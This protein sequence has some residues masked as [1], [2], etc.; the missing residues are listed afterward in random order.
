MKAIAVARRQPA[1]RI[2]LYGLLFLI[3][4]QLLS[5]FVAG[6]YAFG[7]LGTAIPPEI[8]SVLLLFS[9]LLLPLLGKRIAAGHLLSLGLF[10]L[11]S[12]LLEPYL[13]TRGQM[14]VSGVGTSA[15]LL[16]FPTMLRTSARQRHDSEGSFLGAGLALAV[17]MSILIKSVN[18]GAYRPAQ[19]WLQLIDWSLILLTALLL[20]TVI[21][22]GREKVPDRSG[23]A[24]G[25]RSPK[26]GTV[27]GMSIGLSA[28][29]IF[30]YFAY[31]SPNVIARWTGSG[32]HWIQAVMLLALAASAFLFAGYRPFRF[33]LTPRGLWLGNLLFVLSLV[34]TIL[35]HQID[36]PTGPG[37]YPFSEPAGNAL[38]QIPLYLSLILFPIILF[39]FVLLTDGIIAARPSARLLAGSFGLASL[40]LL[41][42]ILAQVF[43]TVYDYIP[44]VGPL[45]RDKFWFVF[46][47]PGLALLAS[48]RGLEPANHLLRPAAAKPLAFALLII[49]SLAMI[50]AFV[51]APAPAKTATSTPALRLLTYNVQ[52]GYNVGGQESSRQQLDLLR[53]I[54][55]D[56]IGLQESDTNRIAGGNSDLVRYFA[57]ELDLYSYYGP[58][59]VPG[60]FGIALLSKYPIEDPR[61]FYMYSEGEQT[62]AIVAQINVGQ[63]KV[64]VVVTHLG[65]GGPIVQQQAVLEE[66][67][68][69]ENLVLMGDFNF[70]P[71]SDPYQLTVSTL[72]DAWLLGRQNGEEEAAQAPENRIDHVFVTP[73]TRVTHARYHIGPQSDHPAMT[74]EIGY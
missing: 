44:V 29:L 71:G 11:A 6:I 36:F 30:I 42:V 27:I 32:R 33:L 70:R 37:A 47:L 31:S 17:A 57:E 28:V 18:S 2:T 5:D 35:P 72:D 43:T 39:D 68:E 51:K 14:L 41:L 20:L 12:R 65:N 46:L 61:T 25:P 15:F 23:A 4:L 60:T 73:G 10:V 16:L 45:F 38:Y 63:E 34:L 40:F 53:Q 67:A 52:Q 48:L 1:L 19:P 59:V 56:V 3:F 66:V 74:V 13:D 64:N 69:L 62:A 24:M 7:L 26:R 54:D 55:P 8:I 21:W 22:S 9:P 49:G 58:K 50:V